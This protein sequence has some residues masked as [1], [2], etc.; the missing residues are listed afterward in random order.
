VRVQYAI[1]T[2]LT[3]LLSLS[4]PTRVF[5]Q[6]P[7]DAAVPLRVSAGRPLEVV[8]DTRIT[9]KRSGQAVAG[10]LVEPLYA[11]DQV[12]APAGTP[13]LGHITALEQPS[14][15]ARTRA[16]LRGDFSPARRVV[17]QF[18]TLMLPDGPTPIRTVVDTEIP[19]LKRTAADAP[20]AHEHQKT[21][22]A[23]RAEQEVKDKVTEGI[24]TAKQ[25][26]RDVLA[27]IRAPGKSARLKNELVQRLPYHPQ[28]IDAGTGYQAELLE[29]VD[30]GRANPREPAARDTRLPPSS[31]LHAR[32]VTTLDSSMSERGA[33][34]EAVVTE[35]V[36]SPEHQ[37]IFP[38][39]TILR[40]EVTLSRPA[41]MLHRN[42]QLRFLFESVQ[43]PAAEATPLLASLQSVQA[44]GDDKVAID[45]EGGATLTN[46][47][48]RFIA[49]T[50]AILALRA[51]VDQHDHLD[52][53]GDGHV[54]H[55]G[56]PGALGVGG[57]IG[58][59][60]VGIPLS[61]IWKPAGL[62][63]T[64]I[65]AVRTTYSNVIGKGREVRFPAHTLIQLQLAPGPST[66]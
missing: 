31:L 42:G 46:S 29:P 11:Y 50:L 2:F 8:L 38:E 9:V 64:A 65:G 24:A 62:A 27:E 45:E 15:F 20:P 22:A 26:S 6:T 56:S 58:A 14:R 40:G 12:V 23:G 21:G 41:R 55:G 28:F 48:T 59:G 25:A 49:P 13:V 5:A 61:M 4:G 63:L 19:H 1:G 10:T 7:I 3:V 32:L 54:I 16:L 47:K 35:P 36:F 66:P 60:I 51:N 39:G 44:S 18:D 17:L 33:P 30:F 34:I 57:F 43:P 53:D 52:P 37:L